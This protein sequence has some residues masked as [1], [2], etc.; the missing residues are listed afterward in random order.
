MVANVTIFEE[1]AVAYRLATPFEIMKFTLRF[2]GELPASG[3]SRKV[4][5]KCE[6]RKKLH[7]QLEE[8]WRI[9]PVLSRVRD[10]GI[11]FPMDQGAH[12]VE[13]HHS[14]S[15]SAAGGWLAEFPNLL[16][17]IEV[18]GTSFIPLVRESMSFVCGLDI[19]FL[20]KEPPGRL[21]SQAG[22]IDG[23]IKTLFDALRMPSQDEQQLCKDTPSPCYCL[24]ESDTLITDLSIR[25]GQLLTGGEKESWVDLVIDVTLKAVHVRGYNLPFLGD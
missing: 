23:R 1:R 7:P 13:W 21:I 22:D 20:R 9:H 6:I 2:E 5:H 10:V 16:A 18:G 24:L 17:P 25:T 12:R 15:E 8:L 19:L 3:N 11:R 4:S 14:M